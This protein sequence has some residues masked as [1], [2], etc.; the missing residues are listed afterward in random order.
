MMIL[1]IA[2]EAAPCFRIIIHQD[3]R[4]AGKPR[5]FFTEPQT[6]GQSLSAIH[7]AISVLCTIDSDR[8]GHTADLDTVHKPARIFFLKCDLV[9]IYDRIDHM[10]P[11]LDPQT[12]N[13][14]CRVP[15]VYVFLCYMAILFRCFSST[16]NTL[17]HC[18]TVL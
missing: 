5:I 16:T 10:C 3:N 14:L 12:Q 1:C 8:D 2:P 17:Q 18:N 7:T 13:V 9:E 6:C 15:I 11:F 4:Y